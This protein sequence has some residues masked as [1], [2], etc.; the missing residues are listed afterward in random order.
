VFKENCPKYVAKIF[1]ELKTSAIKE[2]FLAVIFF[3]LQKLS[4]YLD[5]F[6]IN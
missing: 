5:T 3:F 1:E 6:K 2:H 4:K